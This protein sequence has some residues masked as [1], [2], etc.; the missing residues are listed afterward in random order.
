MVA[1]LAACVGPL[2]FTLTCQKALLIL[3]S[4]LEE[5]T[6]H[7]VYF[8]S[9]TYTFSQCIIHPIKEVVV[10]MGTKAM[11]TSE[12][13]PIFILQKSTNSFAVF[14]YESFFKSLKSKFTFL[15][16]KN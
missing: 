3:Y 10:F 14:S 11:K 4:T 1:A 8:R 16:L 13:Q 6:F 5:H 2:A 15:L 7:Y 9:N 12:M